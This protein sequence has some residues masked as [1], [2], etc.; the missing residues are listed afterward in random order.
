MV[1]LLRASLLGGWCCLVVLVV[2]DVV[3]L[4][5]VRGGGWSD[6]PLS[7]IS[8]HHCYYATTTVVLEFVLSSSRVNRSTIPILTAN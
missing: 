7:T 5:V 8:Y 6:A 4:G 1:R 2:D 3:W